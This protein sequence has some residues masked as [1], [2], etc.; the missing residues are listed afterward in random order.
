M[1]KFFKWTVIILA[2]L[3]TGFYI[4]VTIRQNRKFEAPF[5][6]IQASSDSLIIAKG[7]ALV[8]GPAHCANCH[9]PV[10]DEAMVERGELVSLSGGRVFDLPV[11]K[12]FAKNITPDKTGIGSMSDR[13]F[14][15]A[16]RYGVRK[17]GTA[18]FDIM[19]FHNTSDADLVAIISFLRSQPA[20]ENHVSENDFNFLGKAVKAL[21]IKPVYPDGNV[22]KEVVKDS[23]AEYGK[24]LAVSVANCRGCH[25]NR[26]LMSGAFTGPDFAGGLAFDMETDSGTFKLVTPN[27]TPDPTSRIYGW[28]QQ[29]FINRFRKGQLQP[30]THMPWGPFSR[31]SE[32]ELKAIYK[33]LQTVKPVENKVPVGLVKEY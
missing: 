14:A 33:F 26:D 4:F 20:V 19:P 11:G 1:K 15:R 12:I 23:T 10:K 32:D 2:I 17:D 13:E 16:L 6:D 25:T 30:G 29:Q 8:F 7:Q 3:I 18:L 9:G 5:P 27:L 24:Y 22:P 31:M 28:T 21:L